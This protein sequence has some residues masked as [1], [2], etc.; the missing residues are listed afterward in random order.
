MAYPNLLS[1]YLPYEF[2]NLGFSGNGKG[3]PEVA[4][5]IA[6]IADPAMFVLDY[7]ANVGTAERMAETLPAFIRI[8]RERHPEVPILVVSKIRSAGER[9]YEEMRQLLHDR[10]H[11]QRSTV[12]RLRSEGDANVHFLDGGTLLGDEDAEECTVD[13]VHPTDLGF[14]RMAKSLAPVIRKLIGA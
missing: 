13:G 10:K 5:T 2:I 12:E 1:R 6:G 11:V 14:L 4:R 8:L 7:E 3:E 9:F